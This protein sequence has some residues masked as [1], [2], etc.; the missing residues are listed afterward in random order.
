MLRA[1]VLLLDVGVYGMKRAISL[2]CPVFAAAALVVGAALP[3]SAA[4]EPPGPGGVSDSAL[5]AVVTA[6]GD[7]FF[8]TTDLTALIDPTGAR[9]QHYGPYAS[10]STDS[11]TC[12]PDWA[13]DTY[14]RHFTVHL[15]NDGSFTVT[16]QFKDGSFVTPASDSPPVNYSPGACQTSSVPAG[17]VTAGIVGD[18]HGYFIIPLNGETQT[19]T[20]PYCNAKTSTNANCDTTT[21]INTHFTPCYRTTCTVSTFFFHYSAGGQDLI[22]HEWKNASMDRGGNSGD[23]RSANL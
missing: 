3:V 21:F 9:T 14:D 8:S 19:S 2:L 17:T 10:G 22:M 20:S 11:G 16:E 7:D 5:L 6:V 15:N 4:A 13:N 18:M 1:F 12:G 23:I